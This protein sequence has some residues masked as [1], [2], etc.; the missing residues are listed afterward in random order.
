MNILLEKSFAVLAYIDG[1]CQ[2]PKPEQIVQNIF[3]VLM[4]FFPPQN[5]RI[6]SVQYNQ[7]EISAKNIGC[8]NTVINK[9][10]AEIF[11]CVS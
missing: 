7:I 1:I 8:D 11:E 4:M 3:L 5:S 6:Q 9:V 10:V 2:R